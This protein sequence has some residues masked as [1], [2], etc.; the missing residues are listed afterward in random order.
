LGPRVRGP[1]PANLEVRQRLIRDDEAV[2]LFCRCGLVVLPYLE[3]SQ[4]ALVAAAY[5]FCKPVVVTRTGALPEYVETGET[6]W[7]VPPGDAAALARALERALADP[8]RL[9]R[10][11]RSGRAWCQGQR[12]AEGQAL[13]AL[14]AR[15]A[16]RG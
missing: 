11:G 14:Y 1:L 13:A 10:M 7:V 12:Q 9:A 16:R 15:L 2:D 8:A 5:A 4:S 6:G 3:A